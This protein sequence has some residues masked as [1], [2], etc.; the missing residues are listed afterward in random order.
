M[1]IGSFICARNALDL[2]Y[3]LEL[4]AESLMKFCDELVLCDSESTDGTRQLM[5]RMAD[6]DPRIRVVNM[7]WTDP[8]GVSHEHWKKWIRFAQSHLKSDWC[9]YLDADEVADP[10]P[11]SIA[12]IKEAASQGKCITVDRVNYWRDPKSVIPEG[13]CC[14]RW[15]TRGGPT[16]FP[17]VS[18]WPIHSGEEPIVDNAVLEPRVKIH[19]LGFLR[20]KRAFYRKARSVLSIWFNRFD[21]R[22]EKGEKEDIPVAETECEYTNLLVPATHPIP[23]EVQRWLADRGHFTEKYVPKIIPSPDP[24]IEVTQTNRNNTWN[25]LHCGDYGDVIYAMPLLK[26]LKR[27]NLYFQD[28]NSI[29]KRILER[30]HVLQPLLESQGYILTAKP[31]EGESIHWNAGDFRQYHNYEQSL[32]VSHWLHYKG[33]KHLPRVTVD[34][35]EPWLEGIVP[36][37]VSKG[38]VVIHRSPRYHNVYFQ[39]KL[40]VQHYPDALFLG[41]PDEH[42]RFTEE[43]G[44][45]EHVPTENLLQMAEIIT[46]SSLFMGNQSVGLAIAEGLKHPRAVELCPWQPDVLIGGGEVYW[47]GDGSLKL[48]ALAGKEPFHMLSGLHQVNYLV[49]TSMNPR[50]GWGRVFDEFPSANS[51]AVL[52]RKVRIAKDV[53]DEEAHK[54]V[55]DRLFLREPSYFGLLPSSSSAM[56]DTVKKAMSQIKTTLT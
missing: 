17:A 19:H 20:E 51:F 39:W 35:K 47:S 41:T 16:K 36:S 14:A 10:S 4:S 11:E 31:H 34:L 49:Q 22:L 50:I 21:P 30:L 12:A 48:P 29:C 26:S 45:I 53:P 42:K 8:K 46:G 44:Y 28:R 40:V 32:A 52:K 2:D 27:V 25:V 6:R 55:L 15:C 38:R 9:Y 23:D 1:K 43:F 13:F 7:P 33:Q 18:D 54:M 37:P 3:C 56:M 5:D 24:V